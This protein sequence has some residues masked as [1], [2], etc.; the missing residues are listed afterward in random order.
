[1]LPSSF[2]TGVYRSARAAGAEY[3]A[4]AVLL[5]APNSGFAEAHTSRR[6]HLRSG[7]GMAYGQQKGRHE[8]GLFVAMQT[9]SIP[10]TDRAAPPEAI[11]HADLDGMLVVP[12]VGADDRGRSTGKR[13]C[14]EIVVLVFGLGGP[15]RG[16]H[17]FE[18]GADSVA[19][20]V[21]AIG[22][23]RGRYAADG[24]ADIVVV[25]PGVAALGVD[26]PRAPSVA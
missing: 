21:G 11:V 4:A 1:M 7:C 25:A 6:R 10:R 24:D 12:E 23:K 8:T 18:T 19:V 22:G 16:E 3:S 17:V 15:V 20:L 9:L 5:F 26:Q 14:A 2:I 13:R